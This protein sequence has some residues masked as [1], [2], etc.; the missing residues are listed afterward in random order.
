MCREVDCPCEPLSERPEGRS[1]AA[2]GDGLQRL[3]R[4][5]SRTDAHYAAWVAE[6]E[7][8]EAARK[9]GYRSTTEWLMAL[10]GE[11]A[12]TCRSQVAMAEAR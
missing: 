3:A 5:Q 9:Q 6:A 11:P 12:S 10:S 4:L 1:P 7:R 8:T 2:L